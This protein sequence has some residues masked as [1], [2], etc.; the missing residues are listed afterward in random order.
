MEL[1]SSADGD[2]T[3]PGKVGIRSMT[4]PDGSSALLG[5]TSAPEVVAYNPSDA[6]A[7]L[8]TLDVLNKVRK[9][10][11]SGIVVNPAGPSVAVPVWE[12]AS[13]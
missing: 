9:D 1:P 12:L 10:G 2:R 6:V 5:F 4:M 8:T 11:Y 13:T 3:V 7:A